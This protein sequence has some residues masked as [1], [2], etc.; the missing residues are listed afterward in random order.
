[1]NKID[2]S[3]LSP[4][5]S[6][7]YAPADKSRVLAKAET[8]AADCIIFDLEDAV[9][10]ECKEDAREALRD[11]FRAHPHSN[12]ARIIRINGLDTPWGTEDLM[13]A[14]GCMPDAILVPKVSV[15]SDLTTIFAALAE[16]D[17]PDT[18]RVWAM[19]ETAQGV[20]N[21]AQI[22]QTV[23]NQCSRLDCFV[24]GT[25]D[26]FKQTGISS[27]DARTIAHP[28]LMQ[29]VLAAKAGGLDVLD[30]VFNNHADLDGFLA[31]CDQG[32]HMGMDGTTVIHP[33]QIELANTAYSPSQSAIQEATAIVDAFGK[34][35]NQNKGVI[36]LG[37]AMVERLH[38]QQAQMLLD[39]VAMIS[40][41]TKVSDT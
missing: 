40:R 14:R 12:S 32:A 8:L 9:A 26:L 33:N 6:A 37:G 3:R 16:T 13:A 1:M 35:E 7:L 5:R 23:G 39:K 22:A 27:P 25:N 21:A 30:G 19:I 18:L 20:A 41:H 29:I 15:S 38:L 31:H 28:W 2:F 4:R 34:P 17:A 36:N 10:P 11:H 24:I